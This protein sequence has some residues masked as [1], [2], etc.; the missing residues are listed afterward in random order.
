MGSPQS[1][2][3]AEHARHKVVAEYLRTALPDQED[4]EGYVYVNDNVMEDT[5]C[6]EKPLRKP[7]GL[8]EVLV[9]DWQNQLLSSPKNRYESSLLHM[10]RG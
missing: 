5:G 6:A 1:K 10:V 7:Q 4:S 2:I 3:S 8:S 9:Q